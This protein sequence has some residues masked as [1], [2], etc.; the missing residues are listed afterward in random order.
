MGFGSNDLFLRAELGYVA[1]C[2]ASAVVMAVFLTTRLRSATPESLS[3][4]VEAIGHE[5]L[6]I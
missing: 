1:G 3:L 2:L 6:E 5:P 4:L